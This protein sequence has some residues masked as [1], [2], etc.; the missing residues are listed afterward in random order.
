TTLM[1][2]SSMPIV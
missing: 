1:S 2:F